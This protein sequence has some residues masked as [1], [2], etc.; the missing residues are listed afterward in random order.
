MRKTGIIL[1]ILM[2]ILSLFNYN[3]VFADE[4]P[5]LDIEIPKTKADIVFTVGTTDTNLSNLNSQIN[6]YL[7]PILRDTYNID[8]NV[9][10]V[11]SSTISTNDAGAST[12]FNSWD[13]YPKFNDSRYNAG[14]QLAG[15]RIYTTANVSWTGFWDKANENATDVELEFDTMTTQHP[16][17]WGFTF[18]MQ[19]VGYDKYKF[20]A[21]E[22]GPNKQELV[23]ARIDYWEPSSVG[24]VHGGPLYHGNLNAADSCYGNNGGGDRI[25]EVYG[26]KVKG[27]ILQIVP[28]SVNFNN[29]YNV[30]I[31]VKGNN[32]KIWVDNVLRFNYTDT[33]AKAITKGGYGPY[34]ASQYNTSYKNVSI[35]TGTQKEFKEVLKE[36]EWRSDSE[37]FIINIDDSLN[38]SLGNDSQKGLIA[39]SLISE[40]INFSSTGDYSMKSIF[41][42]FTTSN[43]IKG[44]YIRDDNQSFQNVLTEYAHYV[45]QTMLEGS[46]LATTYIPIDTEL[47]YK[48]HNLSSGIATEYKGY[49]WKLLHDKGYLENSNGISEYHDRRLNAMPEKFDKVGKYT[50]YYG[51]L[52][53]IPK[54]IVVHRLPVAVIDASITNYSTY[55]NVSLSSSDSYDLDNYSSGNKG[56]KNVEWRYKE[57]SATSWTN[58]Q[59]SG[60][61]SKGK[62]YLIQLR[63]Q[64]YQNTWSNYETQLISTDGTALDP[65][66]KFDISDD[67]M[68]EGKDLKISNKSY[69]PSGTAIISNQ[70]E[71]RDA[72]GNKITGFNN[73]NSEF[74]IN[75]N[76]LGINLGSSSSKD[77]KIAL[78]VQDSNGKWSDFY[79]RTI[80]LEKD[81]TAPMITYDKGSSEWDNKNVTVNLGFSKEYG[82]AYSRHKVVT[83][84]SNAQ[85]TNWS[86]ATWNSSSSRSVTLSS[87]GEHYIH[88]LA[89]DTGGN[90]RYVILGPY[91][92]DKTNPNAPTVNLST[93][94]WAASG[95]TFNVSSNNDLGSGVKHIEYKISDGSWDI[96]KSTVTI[97]SHLKGIVPVSA[98][99]VDYTGN[100]SSITTVNAKIDD[101]K[102]T[103]SD[104]KVE[105]GTPLIAS[106]L[107]VNA[108]DNES[109]LNLKAYRYYEKIIGKDSKF[110][111]IKGGWYENKEIELPVDLSATK[112]LYKVDVRDVNE[113]S[114]S[115][116]EVAYVSA[117]IVTKAEVKDG[118][119][120]NV[121]T[122][123]FANKV[124]TDV[125][126]E[127]YRE[128]EHVALI[129]SGASKFVDKGLDYERDYNYEFVAV[130]TFNGKEVKSEPT[131]VKIT[132]GKPTL[133]VSLDN[134]EYYNTVFND[135]FNVTGDVVYRK[136]GN[137]SVK[138]IKDGNVIDSTTV[139]VLPYA[140][141]KWSVG[142]N[143]TGKAKTEYTIEIDLVGFENMKVY[144]REYKVNVSRIVPTV[145]S[146]KDFTKY[147]K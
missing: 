56:I 20:Y 91:R 54:F 100:I 90:E 46:E 26:D 34:T 49:P 142:S 107:V 24:E 80:K 62:N 29:W 66:S 114:S 132:I 2:M 141:T 86:T 144:K 135:G 74:N 52:S 115:S 78:K 8:A 28:H 129:D 71:I 89:Q 125:K 136:G 94:N 57:V 93:T 3:T 6:T 16:D 134:N 130:S 23:L 109:G 68:W 131:P 99:V 1:I 128:G 15:D 18:R 25:C 122:F 31:E 64:D 145:R 27:E 110:N 113:N 33:S 45:G 79:V 67:V 138:L 59:L 87:H 143:Q 42:S 147:S 48:Y 38:N 139:S 117:P 63:V 12:I 102:P 112:Y 96:Y 55:S 104:F 146:I 58:G 40:N 76:S 30:K 101:I 124:G 92:I 127:V 11:E 41:D 137:V 105:K 7:K 133:E 14:W 32:I 121:Y 37:K 108:F 47:D 84:T 73:N 98:R 70:W 9:M 81:K 19:N 75:F 69:H 119:F 106:K 85:V 10:A 60:N 72:D 22:F 50:I 140:K 83:N 44:K 123:D 82:N 95:V 88:V 111:I 39:S 118:D 4:I 51:E 43:G 77:F 36:P 65:V 17:P 53:T 126:I 120:D 103:I 35:T 116:G 13:K 5:R 61:I 97:P 21:L